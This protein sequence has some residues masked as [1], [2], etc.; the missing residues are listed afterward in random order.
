MLST[1]FY[2]LLA[3]SMSAFPQSNSTAMNCTINPGICE[4]GWYCADCG[5]CEQYRQLDDACCDKNLC[6]P[7]LICDSTINRCTVKKVENEPCTADAQCDTALRC[8]PKSDSDDEKTCQCLKQ[9]GDRCNVTDECSIGLACTKDK[10]TAPDEVTYVK[11][12]DDSCDAKDE[13]PGCGEGLRCCGSKGKC[14]RLEYANATCTESYQCQ[15]WLHC[16]AKSE[17]CQLPEMNN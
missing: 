2:M 12:L 15:R 10:C 3:P 16:D 5:L 13:Y 11:Q 17:T 7:E 8:L 1:F 4:V 9:K 14:V 6:A